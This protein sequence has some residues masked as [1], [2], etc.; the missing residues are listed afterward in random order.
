MGKNQINLAVLEQSY[1]IM[2]Y[3]QKEGPARAIDIAN[4][5]DL[6]DS[7]AYNYI[8]SLESIGFLDKNGQEYQ[9]GLKLLELGITARRNYR[10]HNEIPKYLEQLT[11]LTGECASF[12]IE[13]QGQRVLLRV[14]EGPNSVYDNAPVG[15][16][17]QLHLT[18]TGK[19]IFAFLEPDQIDSIVEGLSFV[20]HTENTITTTE[21][22]YRELDKIRRRGY[23]IDN[24]EYTAQIRSVAVPI[25]NEQG[26]SLGAIGLSGPKQR[27]DDATIGEYIPILQRTIEE[28]ELKWAYSK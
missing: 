26:H 14:R 1:N 9:L 18:G 2:E 3:V 19:A 17:R 5:F 6:P 25:T 22:L 28:I 21:S 10:L 24:G 8:S 4:T 7:T 20:S 13:N 16:H 11:A 15:E 12:A 27:F 23:A